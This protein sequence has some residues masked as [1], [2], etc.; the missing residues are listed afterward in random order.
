MKKLI[1]LMIIALLG[2]GAT[3]QKYS[4]TFKVKGLEAGKDVYLANYFGDQLYYYDTAQ[5]ENGVVKFERDEIKGGVYAVVLPGP[6][7]FEVIPMELKQRSYWKQTL[8]TL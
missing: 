7:T 8:L 2:Y 6:K 3:A 1:L 4:F 5:S